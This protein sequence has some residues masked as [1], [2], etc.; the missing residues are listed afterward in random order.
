MNYILKSLA[1]L[2][3]AAFVFH[4]NL[5]MADI[6]IDGGPAWPGSANTTGYSGSGSPIFGGDTWTYPNAGSSPVANLYFGLSSTAGP[7]SLTT[8][9]GGGSSMSWA[10]DGANYI[11]YHGTTVIGNYNTYT[12]QPFNSRLVLTV[13]SGGT[14]VSDATTQ[15]LGSGVHSLIEVTGP[16]F[17]VS[18]QMDI[19]N[20]SSWQ[21]AGSFFN[22]LPT[23]NGDVLQTNFSTG[24]YWENEAVPE[25]AS[26]ALLGLGLAGL[27]FSRRRKQ[28]AA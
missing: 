9:F 14:I 25:P 7:A 4:A 8:A 13:N 26:L 6:V 23:I 5:A 2:A 1:G 12:Y 18:R 3:A 16:S 24:F 21:S 17:S 10:L 19:W 15:A 11:E 28:K 27:G 22:S 20:G